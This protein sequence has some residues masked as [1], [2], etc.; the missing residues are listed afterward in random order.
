M[1]NLSGTSSG[2]NNKSCGIFHH[3]TNKIGLAFF[4]CFYDFLRNLQESA[5]AL[6][7]LRSAFT[8]RPLTGFSDSRT[9]PWFT[10]IS[11]ERTGSPQ[12]GPPGCRPPAA[13]P[14]S[15]EVA[16]GVGEESGGGLVAHLGLGLVGRRGR[17]KTRRGSSVAPG[18]G[19]RGGGKFQR[20][21]GEVRQHAA[22]EASTGSQGGSG[23]LDGDGMKGK[24]QF[25]E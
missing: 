20:G 18:V 25:T 3:E 9:G 24:V 15:G 2:K 23:W 7:Y 21:R 14:D 22:G 11:L 12:L 8:T 16:A 13:L 19:H 1:Q 10:K 17:W 4:W 6:Y 5:K